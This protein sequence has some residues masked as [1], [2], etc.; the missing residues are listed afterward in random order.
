MANEM[1]ALDKLCSR[2]QGNVL[3]QVFHHEQ[4]APD[5]LDCDIHKIDMELCVKNLRNEIKSQPQSLR[6]IL[7]QMVLLKGTRDHSAELQEL[8]VQMSLKTT[9]LLIVLTQI[10]E[11]LQFI[12]SQ[13][14]VH[15]D[16]KP[17]NGRARY[18]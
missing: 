9:E 2:D 6:E 5:G 17:E 11:G 1:R 10:L 3:V 8:S 13:K 4:G 7:N 14:E 16:L 18:K 15:R 12:H